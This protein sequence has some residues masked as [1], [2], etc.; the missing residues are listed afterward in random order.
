MCLRDSKA[1]EVEMLNALDWRIG[2]LLWG[3]GTASESENLGSG[4]ICGILGLLAISAQFTLV[5][6]LQFLG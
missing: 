1:G 3:A 6:Y 5:L 2:V 4:V